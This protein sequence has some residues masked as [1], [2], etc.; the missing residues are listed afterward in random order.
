VTDFSLTLGEQYELQPYS[1]WIAAWIEHAAARPGT[2]FDSLAAAYELRIAELAKLMVILHV[3]LLALV[4]MLLTVDKRLYYADHVVAALH[5]FAFLM[6]CW[7]LLGALQGPLAAALGVLSGSAA[8]VVAASGLVVPLFYVPFMLRTAFALA[9]WRAIVLVPL[10]VAG[11]LV[12]HFLY[13][14]MQFLIGFA[15][16]P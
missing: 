3:P 11:L 16:L 14:L 8:R 12:V 15:S 9:W 2:T 7:S 1:A 5:F 4:T 13:R 10:F 6:L